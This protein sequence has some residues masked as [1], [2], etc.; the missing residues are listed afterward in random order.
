MLQGKARLLVKDNGILCGIEVAKAVFEKV[1]ANLKTD[2][3]IKEGSAI[4]YG[5]IAFH[6]YGSAISI[7]T[8]ERLVLNCMQRMS[9]IATKTS[10]Y[11]K[12]IEGTKCKSNRHQENDTESSIFGEILSDC[13]WWF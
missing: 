3:H 9:G 10:E 2:I 5:D 1:D 4:K 7:L 13:W 6:V 12:A 11:V 8:A